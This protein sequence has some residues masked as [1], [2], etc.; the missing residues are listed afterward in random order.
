L[1]EKILIFKSFIFSK[2]H[3]DLMVVSC[4]ASQ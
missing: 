1:Q 4:L 2:F 3:C